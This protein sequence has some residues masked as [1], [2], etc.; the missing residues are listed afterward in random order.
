MLSFVFNK[1][2]YPTSDITTYAES[3]IYILYIFANT[4][5]AKSNSVLQ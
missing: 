3:V 1:H 2:T 4:F 5:A